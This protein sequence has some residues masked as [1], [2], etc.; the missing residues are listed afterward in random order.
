MYVPQAQ[1]KNLEKLV[2]PGKALIVYG[3]R[4]TGKTTLVKRYCESVNESYL[5]VDGEDLAVRDALESHSVERLKAF[6]GANRL[7]V[8]DEAQSI[9]KIGRNLKLLID[10]VPDLKIIATG[11]SSFELAKD[12]GEP[13]TGRS[14]VLHMYPLAQ[15]EL[16]SMENRHET[17]SCL[18]ERLVYG[19]YPE[20]VLLRDDSLRKRHL[21]TMVGVYLFKDILAHE[22][23]RDSDKLRRLLQLLAFQIGKDVSHNE[24]ATQL[25]M[26]KNTVARYLDLLEKVFV[27][28]H[29]NGFSRNLRKELSKSN[30]YYFFDNGVRNALINN[31]NP[32]SL[33]DDAGLLWE[34][35]VV[36]ERLKRNEYGGL[37]VSSWFWR[38]YDRKEIDLVEESGGQLRGYEM[39]WKEARKTSAP[40]DWVKQYPE[41]TFEVVHPGN[42][43]PFI[44]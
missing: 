42:Y 36:S 5:Y 19:S 33:R 7:L 12:V 37:F 41:A 29:R 18:E 14:Y 44:T 20:V 16:A 10:H 11:S 6:V 21:S 31:F 23:V 34:N 1:L 32:L 26:S 30:R 38:T 2:L 43:L 13:L 3:A 35:Y 9:R 40:T 22:N 25:G 8:V 39:K 27:I 17:E 28:F 4:Q 15:L 24:L